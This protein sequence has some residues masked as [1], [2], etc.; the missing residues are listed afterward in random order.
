MGLSETYF[1]RVGSD[2][3]NT[4]SPMSM[5]VAVTATAHSASCVR[6]TGDKQA[7]GVG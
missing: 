6:P 5:P 4:P 1:L 3:V 7:Q 2:G